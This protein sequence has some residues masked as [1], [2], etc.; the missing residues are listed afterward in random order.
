MREY[1]I[2]ID[3]MFATMRHYSVNKVIKPDL[4]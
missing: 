2:P 4:I 3:Y 1:S